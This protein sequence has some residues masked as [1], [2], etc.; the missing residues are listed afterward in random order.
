MTT[1]KI[2]TRQNSV[3]CLGGQQKLGHSNQPSQTTNK[4]AACQVGIKKRKTGDYLSYIQTE[5][6]T[7]VSFPSGLKMCRKKT[8]SI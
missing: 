2:L 1:Q 5:S 7:D 6:K 4:P 8:D 3:L